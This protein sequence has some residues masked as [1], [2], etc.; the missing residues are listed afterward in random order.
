[1]VDTKNRNKLSPQENIIGLKLPLTGGNQ[2]T[3]DQ[4]GLIVSKIKI[5][6]NVYQIVSPNRN[7]IFSYKIFQ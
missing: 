1:M 3:I 2:F 7:L 6:M 4:H 5:K